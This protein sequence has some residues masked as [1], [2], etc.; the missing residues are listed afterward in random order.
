MMFSILGNQPFVAHANATNTNADEW[1]ANANGQF[2]F[3]D[4][5][6][7]SI[8]GREKFPNDER[9]IDA[10]NNHGRTLLH[11]SMAKQL[12]GEYNIARTSYELILTAPA[13]NSSLRETTAYHFGYAS[14]SKRTPEQYYNFAI[15][16]RHFVKRVALFREGFGLYNAIERQIAK[17]DQGLNLSAQTLLQWSIN[18]YNEKDYALSLMGLEEILKTPQISN[19]LKQSA[20]SHHQDTLYDYSLRH[21]H[22]TDRL[23][24]AIQGN[25]L[26]PNNSRFV[27]AIN[28]NA[29][30]LLN[31]TK[32]RHMSG[33]FDIAIDRYDRILA[34]P[35][36]ASDIVEETGYLNS[37]VKKQLRTPEQYYEYAIRQTHYADRL[38]K[39]TEGFQLYNES[40]QN[41]GKLENGLNAS[42]QTFLN[43]SIQKHNQK[44][45]ASAK[46]GLEN[47]IATSKVSSTIKENATNVYKTVLY[48]YAMTHPHFT[49]RLALSIEGYNKYPTDIRFTNAINSSINSLLHWSIARQ[50]NGAFKV[51]VDSYDRILA[52]PVLDS[53]IKSDVEYY[54]SFAIQGKRTPEQHYEIFTSQVHFTDRLQLAIDGYHLYPGDSRFVEAIN[55]TASLLLSWTVLRQTEG[56]Y[57]LS[58]DRYNHILAAPVL[59]NQIKLNVEY[60]RNYAL[61]GKRTPEQYYD[62]AI[63]QTH[64]TD[65]V[66]LFTE[67]FNIYNQQEREVGRIQQGL[68]ASAN[69]L[70]NWTVQRHNLAQFD[71]AIANYNLII[72]NQLISLAIR[73]TASENL[74]WA[75][76]G[77]TLETELIEYTSYN[78]TLSSYLDVQMALRNPAPQ[79]D[80]YRNANVFIHSSLLAIQEEGVITGTTVNLRS[81]PNLTSVARSVPQGTVVTI[82]E[83]VIGE[84]WNNSDK[85]Y[86]IT[87]EGNTYFVHSNLAQSRRVATVNGTGVHIRQSAS[88]SAHSFGTIANNTI[89]PVVRN[90]S[91]TVVSG[92][93]VWYE[94]S[95]S[96]D[97]RNAPRQDVEQFLNPNNNN[98]L[99]HLVISRNLGV[100]AETLNIALVGKRILENRGDAFSEGARLYSVNEFYL[101][102]HAILETGHGSS[103]LAQGI[104]VDTNGN[105]YRDNSGRLI[106]DPS[107]LPSTATKVYN[108]YGIAAVDSNPINGGARYAYQQGW[109]T[110]DKAIIG[111]AKWISDNYVNHPT[112][113]Q[114]T[115]YKMR[116]NP[117]NPGSN[118]YAS[119]IRWTVKQAST[120]EQLYAQTNQRALH[121]NIP[122]L[123]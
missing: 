13:L 94:L 3:T 50:T 74:A 64:F 121:F 44:D 59:D 119:D 95:L 108:M 2:H 49:E 46:F 32:P 42:A 52:S 51:A 7:L 34:A 90:V 100:P 12:E 38:L 77:L 93:D 68:N 10:I 120:I 113:R 55:T 48:D 24:L 123:R 45:Y 19:N 65:R 15:S 69:S 81:E 53:K 9:F 41:R 86:R 83:E 91:G 72:G 29:R 78:I 35:R 70:L 101:I 85:W 76:K 111:G 22:F 87:Y 84:M 11:W 39:F 16:Q 88:T 67:A 97:W 56:E 58:I 54:R 82:E 62:F 37:Y 60:A 122:R 18:K 8:E 96:R 5:L 107:K 43:W 102:S 79:T 1:L 57:D 63:K 33:E 47:I 99:Q 98:R 73:D 21:V 66:R 30:T 92:S 17:F 110:P 103:T 117:A 25:R 26:Y 80:Q 36:L 112:R 89:L 115:I 105:P 71:I 6:K 31:W 109:V 75:E 14:Q 116:W 4:R 61:Q 106:T 27:Q 114:D 23:A 104:Y 28:T 20:E 40:E 118:Q